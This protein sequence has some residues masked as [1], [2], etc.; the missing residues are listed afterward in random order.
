MKE[1]LW[2]KF[3]PEKMWQ[4]SLSGVFSHQGCRTV[5]YRPQNSHWMHAEDGEELSS[6]FSLFPT[7]HPD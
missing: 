3:Y 5:T 4:A 1:I 2:R 7:C 6:T